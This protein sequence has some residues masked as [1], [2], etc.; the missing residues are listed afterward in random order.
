VTLYLLRHGIAEDPAPG[1]ADR[2]RRLTP[3]GRVRMRRAAAG[4][5]ALV[6]RVDAIFTSPYPRAAETAALAAAAIPQA[7]KPREIDA[8]AAVTSPMETLRVLRTIA[9]G[10]RIV[11]VGHEPGLSTLASLLLTG[12]VDG[13]RI[14]LKKGGCI[15]LTIRAP[16]PRAA[17]LAWIATPRMLRRLGRTSTR[18]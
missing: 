14:D 7:P 6:G 16:R 5:A 9:K 18:R 11:L 1:A 4:L 13:A 3:H 15:A 10:D 12:S 2:D 17:E 8:L